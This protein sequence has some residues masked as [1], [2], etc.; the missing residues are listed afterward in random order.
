MAKRV[1]ERICLSRH[2][3]EM[4]IQISEMEK[5]KWLCSQQEGCDV[6]TAAYFKWAQKYAQRV[7]HW[8]ESLPDEEVD[9][10]YEALSDHIKTCI[11]NKAH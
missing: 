9:R 11:C 1:A 7:R 8:L 6:G 3:K 4:G 5:Y 10:L 2:E